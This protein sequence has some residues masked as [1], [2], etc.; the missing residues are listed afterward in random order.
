MSPPP[1]P[2]LRQIRN[3]AKDLWRAFKSGSPEAALRFRESIPQLAGLSDTDVSGAKLGLKDAQRAIAAEYGF[4]DW[5]SLRRHVE[6]VSSGNQGPVYPEGDLPERVAAILR[7]VEEADVDRVR[8]LLDD[9]PALVHVRVRSDFE[10]GDTLLH[11]SA[12]HQVD[13]GT[14][15]DDPHLQVAQMLIDHGADIDAVGDTKTP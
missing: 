15:P 2:D 7:A 1:N 6:A 12:P 13:D 10:E 14:N 4:A 9:D 8:T 3:Q 5:E 11:R